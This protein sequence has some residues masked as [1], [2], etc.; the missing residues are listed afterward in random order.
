MD[1]G[2]GW[3]GCA[4]AG[5]QADAATTELSSPGDKPAV[6]TRQLVSDVALTGRARTKTRQDLR[7]IG[8]V[9]WHRTRT[10]ALSVS[11]AGRLI[12]G[13]AIESSIAKVVFSVS[14]LQAASYRLRKSP[15]SDTS[16]L[17]LA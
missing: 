13:I 6:K 1:C 5:V 7:S 4:V 9:S 14:P 8:S 17:T 3:S 2:A 12:V 15:L 16:A 10:H 11:H